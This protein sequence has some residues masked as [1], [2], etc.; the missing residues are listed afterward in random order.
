MVRK[1]L[2]ELG[3][4]YFSGRQW[5]LIPFQP[6]LYLFI[7]GVAIRLWISDSPPPAFDQV[8]GTSAFYGF[9]L[10]LGLIGP[11][12][13]LLSWFQIRAGG[14]KR[15]VGLWLRFAGDITVFAN[16]ISYH[17]TVAST[18]SPS[19]PRIYS[20]YIVGSALIFTLSLIVRDIW[21]LVLVERLAIRIHRDE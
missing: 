12:L 4:R 11:L 10:A 15:F 5:P 18:I 9:W 3:N 17:I 16:L 13:A 1:K 8:V 21:T 6:I 20:R 7:F 14:K 19:E 2:I